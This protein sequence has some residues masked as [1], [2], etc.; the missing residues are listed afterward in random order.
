MKKLLALVLFNM[1]LFAA[2]AL[3][4]PQDFTLVNNSS[5]FV[6]YVYV[7]PQGTSDWEEDVLNDDCLAPGESVNIRFSGGGQAMWDLRVEDLD[8]NYEEYYGFNLNSLSTITI[9]G[10]GEAS[11]R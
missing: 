5:S 6:C 3:A 1:L 7:S 10:G 9:K 2:P 8:G 4:G 11:Y